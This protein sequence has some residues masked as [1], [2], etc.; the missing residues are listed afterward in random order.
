MPGRWLLVAIPLLFL[1]SI[2]LPALAHADLVSVT[3]PDGAVNSEPVERFDLVFT[4]AVEPVESGMQLLSDGDA[5]DIIVF[6]PSEATVVVEPLEAL[7]SGRY[8]LIW[9]VQSADS[10]IVEGTTVGE[11]VVPAGTNEDE[12]ASQLPGTT[13]DGE[14]VETTPTTTI[15][16]EDEP[17]IL[18]NTSLPPS[19][20]ETAKADIAE[21][22]PAGDWIAAVGRWIL[23]VGGLLAIGAFVFAGTSLVGTADEVARAVRWVRRGGALVLL[24]TLIEVLGVSTSFAGSLADALSVSTLV[25]VLAGTFGVAVLLRL[26]GGVAL[27]ADPRLAA[28]VPVSQ[29]F[30]A[31]GMPAVD[32]TDSSSEPGSVMTE[33]HVT[34]YR[35]DMKQEW[36]MIAGV[37]AVAASFA[38]DGHTAVVDPSVLARASSF[39]HVLA[40]GVWFG[41]LVVLA[42]TLTRRWRSDAQLDAGATVVRFSRSASVALGV[43]AV[44]GLALTWTILESPS[45]LVSSTWGRLL[46]VKVGL[47]AA[48]VGLGAYNHFKVV[49]DLDNHPRDEAVASR[50]RV[51]VR[52]EA[53]GLAIVIAVTAVLVGVAA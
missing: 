36:V 25:D 40:G 39:V 48:V 24:G 42:D 15:A 30:V 38:F 34:R 10:H 47:V 46:L 21:D 9:K 45:E 7:T 11:V 37:L 16:V 18:V 44:A 29:S 51:V 35:L 5:V 28:T 4:A 17:L 1:I 43:V 14:A 22:A 53:I 27:L 2:A 26:A 8:A 12:S 23:M 19:A 6:Q 13:T 49:P 33:S 50:L 41:G 20:F 52:A 31:Q 32:G 3:P